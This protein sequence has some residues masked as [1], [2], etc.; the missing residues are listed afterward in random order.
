MRT[1]VSNQILN[2]KGLLQFVNSK[3]GYDFTA[4]YVRG[5]AIY[6]HHITELSQQSMEL[7]AGMTVAADRVK[8]CPRSYG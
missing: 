8:E 1:E 7:G 4:Y 2:F 5:Q 6:P 3:N